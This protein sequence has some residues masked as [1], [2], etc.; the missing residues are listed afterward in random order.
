M[1][2]RRLDKLTGCAVLW[3]VLFSLEIFLAQPIEAKLGKELEIVEEQPLNIRAESLMY[4]ADDNLYVA[5]GSVEITY[6]KSVLTAD[7]VEFN[8]VTGDAVAIGNVV[9]E[10]ESETII[11]DQLELNFDTE[12]GIIHRGEVALADDHYITGEEIKKIAESTYLISKGS[13]SACSSSRPAW[14]FRSSSAKVER[15]EYL[16]S[17]NTVG[18]IKGIPVFYLPFFIFPIK[19]KRQSGLLIPDIG[20]SSSKG[21]TITNAFF[22]AISDSQDATMSHTYYADRGH[23]LSLEYRYIYSAETDG[24]LH[25]QYIRDRIDL[26]EKK[27]LQWTHRHGLAYGIK[28]RMNVNLSSDD[29]FDE[30]FETTLDTRT[31]KKLKSDLSFTKNFSQHTIRLMLDRLDDL[32][33]EGAD[34]SDQRFPELHITSQQQQLFGTPLYIQQRTQISRLKREGN[35][36][37]ELEF[38]RLDFQ[39]TLSLPLNLFGQALTINPQIQFRET[40]YTR[41]ATTAADHSL[42]AKPVQREYYRFDV[43]V[44]GPKFNRIFDLGTDRRTQKLKHLI[45]PTFSFQ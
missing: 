39:P 8:E 29:L 21:F 33:P 13:Y 24:N 5:E 14:Q 15:G 22:W 27:R 34:R 43:S 37:V 3:C 18:Y 36:G 32:R 7:R 20:T 40:Y 16:Q 31:N 6:R 44:N 10:E 23:K 11:A 25:G 9:Y 30:D 35:D 38:D 26:T 4:L 19:T 45:E 28:A 42:D 2:L 12:L 17:W 41:D 1:H